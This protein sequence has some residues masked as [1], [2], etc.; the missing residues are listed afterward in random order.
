MRVN[1]F[2]IKLLAAVGLIGLIGMLTGCSSLSENDAASVNGTIITKDDVAKEISNMRKTYGALV[3]S[4]SDGD[5]YTNF[6]RSTAEKL[7]FYKLMETEAEDKGI[8]I[9][10]ADIEQ[11]IQELADESFLGEPDKLREEYFN[12]GFTE[13]DIRAEAV[14][15]ILN[16]KLQAQIGKDIQVTD[17][18]AQDYYER[19]RT[20]YDQPERRQ[21]RQLVTDKEADAITAVSKARSGESF[22]TLVEQYSTD[23]QAQQKKG[24]MGKMVARGELPPEL[25]N[26]IFDMKAGDISNPVKL[27]EQWYVFSLEYISPANLRTLD[28]VRD[29]IK[30]IYGAQIFS[31]RWKAY[32]DQV[33]SDASI[34]YKQDYDPAFKVEQNTVTSQ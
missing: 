23:P 20:Q 17:Q 24:A 22:I 32:G 7:V 8:S 6:V 9:S 4:E 27:G 18:D 28:Q 11:H 26:V 5:V 3:P 25:E 33:R 29:E 10:E 30:A 19:N 12:K 15:A 2:G 13:E 21:A 16:E 34:E 1:S 31:E 14:R